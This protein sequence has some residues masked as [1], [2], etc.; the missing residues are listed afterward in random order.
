MGAAMVR[1]KIPHGDGL[2]GLEVRERTRLP[3]PELRLQG[4]LQAVQCAQGGR[5]VGAP[6]GPPDGHL[7]LWSRHKAALHQEL[8]RMPGPHHAPRW[9]C[10]SV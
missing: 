4:H 2:R 6:P 8:P 9:W 1:M 5:Q 7:R 10:C 3:L